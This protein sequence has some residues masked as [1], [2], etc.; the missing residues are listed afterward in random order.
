MTP[1]GAPMALTRSAEDTQT[2]L[3]APSKTWP[4]AHKQLRQVQAHF[5][6]LSQRGLEMSD[7]PKPTSSEGKAQVPNT[8]A[9]L[10][11][12]QL[13]VMLS[14]GLTVARVRS[15]ADFG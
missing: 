2:G 8:R 1:F 9:Q 10:P 15:L 6:T 12:R 11:L 5:S 3:A 13:P 7:V 4:G 14:M